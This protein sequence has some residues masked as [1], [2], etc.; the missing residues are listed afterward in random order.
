MAVTLVSPATCTGD[1]RVVVVPSPSSP[2]PFQP[3]VQTVPSARRAT[4]WNA[5]AARA[6]APGTPMPTAGV[7]RSIAVPSPSWVT[8]FQP[9]A[10]VGL[11]RPGVTGVDGNE[12]GPSPATRTA[13]TVNVYERPVVRPVT[14]AK[15][16]AASRVV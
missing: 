13:L 3:Q 11:D 1:G 9:Q 16:W 8:A 5:P 4:L 6:M 7:K 15:R 2:Y 10:E 12:G 14:R